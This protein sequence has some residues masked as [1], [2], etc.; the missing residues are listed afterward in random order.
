MDTTKPGVRWEQ[1]SRRLRGRRCASA[2][3][4]ASVDRDRSTWRLRWMI[5]IGRSCSANGSTE[6]GGTPWHRRSPDGIAAV[7]RSR[8][9]RHDAA[10]TT[11]S[12]HRGPWRRAAPAAAGR[13]ASSPTGSCALSARVYRG[14]RGDRAGTSSGLADREVG[15]GTPDGLTRRRCPSSGDRHAAPAAVR[16]EVSEMAPGHPP[17]GQVTIPVWPAGEEVEAVRPAR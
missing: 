14:D 15:R 2:L 16:A 8:T 4:S 5:T 17:V 9:S 3:A 13:R 1:P 11:T 10:G 6:G 12:R 7:M